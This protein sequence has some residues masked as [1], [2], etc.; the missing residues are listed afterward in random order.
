MDRIVQAYNANLTGAEFTRIFAVKL[1]TKMFV[2][3]NIMEA[4]SLSDGPKVQIIQN[5]ATKYLQAEQYV[6]C[7]DNENVCVRVG[8]LIELR[9]RVFNEI[10]T[11]LT[12]MTQEDQNEVLVQ[13]C[14]DVMTFLKDTYFINDFESIKK[15]AKEIIK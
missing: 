1:S 8:D 7:D 12:L 13:F 11:A 14:I 5:I 15:I 9:S 2:L 4:L 3:A 10:V 6:F